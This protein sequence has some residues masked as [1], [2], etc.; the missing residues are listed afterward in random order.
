MPSLASVMGPV[1]TRSRYRAL[2]TLLGAL[3]FTALYSLVAGAQTPPPAELS[4]LSLSD[5]TLRPAFAVA[6]TE[7]R[8][9]VKHNVSQI[10]VTPMAAAGVT[11]EYLDASDFTLSDADG[12][13]TG[14]QVDLAVG[15]TAF[16]VKVTSGSDT[17]SYTVTVE[18][19][20]A[21]V[22]GWTPSRDINALEAAGNAS[23]QGIWS[24]GTTMWVA[25]DEDD[26]LYAYTL[27][28]GVRDA[29]KDIS[30]HSDNG[31]PRGI[32]SDDTTIWVADDEDDKLYAYT[33]ATGARD[34]TEEFDLD[35][36]NGDPAGI[37]SDGTTIW[38]A[39]NKSVSVS[40]YKIFAYT[41]SGGAR[42]TAKEFVPSWNPVGIWAHGTTM[43]VVNHVGVNVGTRVNAY[44]IDLNTDGTAGPSHGNWEN[45]KQLILESPDGT[46][47]VGIWLDGTGAVWI[48]APDSPKVESYN[49]LP[50]SAGSTTLSALTINDGTSDTTL[51]P[52]FAATTTNYNT[53][54]TD[55]VNRVTVSATPSENTATVVY[56]D[57]ADEALED[58]DSGTTGFQVAVRQGTTAI[59]VLVTAQ[60]GT[61]LIHRVIVERDAA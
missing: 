14:F 47:P 4:A 13:T 61:A 20:S 60:D 35:A 46:S 38:V 54:V 29:T 42:D 43:W 11:V 34:E 7:Y 18:R 40:P 17:E 24:E 56:L 49:M 59:H 50:F 3:V 22:F 51:R 48:T 31:D 6:T 30:L 41:L 23:P 52:T 26:K 58:A 8:A 36:D 16:K 21:Y 15:E 10:T 12:D 55:D 37:W 45:D 5:G 39:N 2:L 19:D 28:T 27:A 57:E 32:W 25:D 33:L 1:V 44:T 53:S 9:A